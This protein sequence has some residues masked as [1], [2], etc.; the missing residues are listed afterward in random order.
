M[1]STL[2]TAAVTVTIAVLA[3]A[4]LAVPAHA[5]YSSNNLTINGY[6]SFE[7]EK[8]ISEEGNGDPNG[9][10]DADLF[11]IVVNF[12]VTDAIRTSADLTWEHGAATEDGRGNVAVEYAFVEYAFNDLF[13]VRVGKMF[14][15]FG[16]YNEIH[17]AKPAFLTVKE[18]ASTNKTERILSN[19]FR[20]FPRWGAGIAVRGD[21]LIRDHNFSYD[22]FVSNGD[23]DV[24]NPFEEDNNVEKAVTARFRFEPTDSLEIGNSF[25]YDKR[26]ADSVDHITSYGLELRYQTR[27]WRLLAESAFGWLTPLDGPAVLQVGWY[28]QP[29][30]EFRNGV[31]PYVRFEWLDSNRDTPDDQ[32]YDLIVGVN[33][34]V[35]PGFMLKLENNKYWGG[36]ASSLAQFPGRGYNEVKA[37]VVL[38]F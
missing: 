15:P 12:Q 10:F 22:V 25:Y 20:Y 27:S 3:L 8:Q 21:G 33:Y 38:G 29:S 7:F 31:S 35:S 16:I 2:V 32:G 30:Y 17:T 37:A 34:E 24:T 13:K 14:T 28:V 23:Q 5:Q 9:S 26:T 19:G 4:G 1:R 36:S 18:P 6:S 11:D